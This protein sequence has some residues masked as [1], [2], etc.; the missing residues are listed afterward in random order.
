MINGD[1]ERIRSLHAVRNDTGETLLT[2]GREAWCLAHLIIN[3]DKGVTP[4]ERPAPR[5]SDYVFRLR[6]RGLPVQTIEEAHGGVYRGHHARY[7]LDVP[8]TVVETEFAA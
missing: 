5:W 8:M 6:K 4:I 3:G 2:K 1:I 7:R